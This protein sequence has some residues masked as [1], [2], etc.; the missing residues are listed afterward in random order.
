MMTMEDDFD[1]AL[2][3]HQVFDLTAA[4]GRSILITVFV[5]TLFHHH[6]ASKKNSRWTPVALQATFLIT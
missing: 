2:D 3:E 4:I 1:Y 6:D 5:M